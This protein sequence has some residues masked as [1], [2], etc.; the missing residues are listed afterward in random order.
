MDWS[1]YKN[2]GAD[3]ENVGEEVT[4]LRESRGTCL[5]LAR[6]CIYYDGIS[7]SHL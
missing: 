5:Q 2:D 1:A 3:E 4:R 6:I 7:F